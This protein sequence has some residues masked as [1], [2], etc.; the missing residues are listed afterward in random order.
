MSLIQVPIEYNVKRQPGNPDIERNQLNRILEDIAS[1]LAS[2]GHVVGNYVTRQQ[3]EDA[4]RNIVFPPSGGG[5]QVNTVVGGIAISVNNSDPVN[6]IVNVDISGLVSTDVGNALS[7]G[8]DGLLYATAGSGGIAS[9]Q[10]GDYTTVD[11]TDPDNPV[12]DVDL[13]ETI[14]TDADNAI[15]QGTDG[16]LFVTTPTSGSGGVLPMVTGEILD[17]QPV[18]MYFDDGSLMYLPVED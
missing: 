14:S 4:I 2:A 5:G 17:G 10:P 13:L 6:P 9:V 18:F 8:G 11:N 15:V 1:K 7:V 3:L 16:R 12:V